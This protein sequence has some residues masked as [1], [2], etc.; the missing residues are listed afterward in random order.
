[1][2]YRV[3]GGLSDT[4]YRGHMFFAV[5]FVER[6]AHYAQSSGL[7]TAEDRNMV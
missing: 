3:L 2:T 6:I 1:M 7:E 4:P 5:D